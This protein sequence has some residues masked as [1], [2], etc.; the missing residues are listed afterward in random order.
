MIKIDFHPSERI[1]RQFAW[2]ALFAFPLLALLLH[3]KW[4]LPWT[5]CWIMFGA[6]A[7]AFLC[8]VLLNLLL[9]PRWMFIGLSVVTVPIGMVL[10]WV[11]VRLIYYGMFTPIA[12]V[13]RLMGRDAM[14]RRRDPARSSYWI[15]RG[16]ARP[17]SSYFKLY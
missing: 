4:G 16:S 11:L 15:D 12:A 1:L 7:A 2:I 17:A 8:G 5:W 6:G 10:S 14:Q 9:V 13:F 3:W